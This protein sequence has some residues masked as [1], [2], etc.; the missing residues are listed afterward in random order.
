MYLFYYLFIIIIIIFF[1]LLSFIY[2]FIYSYI[3]LIFCRK[4]YQTGRKTL[5][6]RHSGTK[7]QSSLIAN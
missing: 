7:L 2:S 6:N 5:I 4:S 1:F 3:Q